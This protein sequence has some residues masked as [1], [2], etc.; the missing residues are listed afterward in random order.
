RAG[1]VDY[2]TNAGR[3]RGR[4]IIKGAAKDLD[5]RVIEKFGRP[6]LIVTSPPYPGVHVLYHRWQILGRKETPA[7]FWIADSKDGSGLSYYTFG[8]R[9]S[10][11]LESYFRHAQ[12]NFHTIS[13]ACLP[14]TVVVQ[15]VAFSNPDTQLPRYLETMQRV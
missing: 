7:P 8:D 6:N 12:A 15:L 14:E 4:L 9:K 11:N 2:R 13:Q 10:P 5:M 3:G 1:A